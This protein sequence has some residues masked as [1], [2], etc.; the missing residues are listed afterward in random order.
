MWLRRFET[1]TTAISTPLELESHRFLERLAMWSYR[2]H[3][4]NMPVRAV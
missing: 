1:S 3:G 2:G 4:R